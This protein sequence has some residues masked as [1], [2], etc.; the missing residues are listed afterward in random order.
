MN[1]RK[2]VAFLLILYNLVIFKY[3]N[4]FGSI[5]YNDTY[6]LESSEPFATFHNKNIYIYGCTDDICS[7]DDINIIDYRNYLLDPNISIIDS[8]KYYSFCDMECILSIV[9]KYESLY[10]S[11]WN[12]SIISMEY[13]W[14]WHNI[15][16][17]LG[18]ETS[19]TKDVDLNNAD[20]KRLV[21]RARN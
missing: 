5:K 12:R 14:F 20:E 7:Y 13:E 16:Y 18:Y 11:N 19:H 21:P 10:P 8:Y 3:L 1:I 17:Y 9:K 4:N 6:S 15:G 2:K